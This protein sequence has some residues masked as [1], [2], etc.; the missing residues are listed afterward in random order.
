MSVQYDSKGK[1]FTQIL[2]KET[3]RSRIQLPTHLVVGEI[4]LRKD[5]R[6]K[7]SIEFAEQFLAITDVEVFTVDGEK[8]LFVAPFLTVNRDHIIWLVLED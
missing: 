3:V 7:D 5:E 8:R 6:V 2:R 4:H 1:S